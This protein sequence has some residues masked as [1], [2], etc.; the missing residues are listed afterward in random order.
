MTAEEFV[1]AFVAK[2]R[3]QSATFASYGAVGPSKTCEAIAVD[4]ESDFRS[5]WLAALSIADAAKES[6][7]S[8]ERLREMAR[9]DELLHKKGAGAR[10]HVTIARRDLPRRPGLK[11]TGIAS[12]EER[13]L[14]PRQTDLQKPA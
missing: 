11:P 3:A 7:Y 12:L 6:G 4:L 5:W 8:E 10:G 1:G 9:D 2:L 14:R 13:L